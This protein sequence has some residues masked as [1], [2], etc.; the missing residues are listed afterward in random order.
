MTDLNQTHTIELFLTHMNEYL[1]YQTCD[2][3]M[4][5]D[6]QNPLMARN[7]EYQNQFRISMP[8]SCITIPLR[9]K[10]GQIKQFIL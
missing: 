6:F 7:Y 5:P 10:I 9:I 8:S 1:N 3:Q 4:V 2:G